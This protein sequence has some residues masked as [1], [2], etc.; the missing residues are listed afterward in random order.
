MKTQQHWQ[1]VY[2]DKDSQKVSWYQERAGL[3]LALISQ[4]LTE[5]SAVI[6]DVGGGASKLVDDLLKN[7]Y[8]NLSVLDIS[9]AALE[10]AKTRLGEKSLDVSWLVQDINQLEL[11]DRSVD[12]WHD[13]AVFHFLTDEDARENYLNNVSKVIK[14][15][16]YLIIAT[17]AEDG[18]ERCSGL[19]VRRHSAADLE[20]FF[21]DNFDRLGAKKEIHLTPA[22]NEQNFI[23]CWFQ[24]K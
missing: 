6:L 22:G 2:S 9:A 19:P 4:L 20:E 13:R 10:V 16:G 14:S 7:N 3:S 24:K 23:Y 18:P 8:D 1:Q 15:G 17:F 12:L 11:Q 5:K 21:G